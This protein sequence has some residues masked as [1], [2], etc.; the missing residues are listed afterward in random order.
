M[1]QLVVEAQP[2]PV[3][4]MVAQRLAA[5]VVSQREEPAQDRGAQEH[6]RRSVKGLPRPIRGYRRAA[7]QQDGAVH[8]VPQKLGDHDLK[9]RRHQNRG[10]GQDQPQPL[11]RRQLEDPPQDR[12]VVTGV[13]V[14]LDG[15]AGIGASVYVLP[16]PGVRSVAGSRVICRRVV[17]CH[18]SGFGE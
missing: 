2:Q 4:Q 9:D 10:R 18:L 15:H 11:R 3:R 13:A 8:R 1:L 16:R 17:S 14:L 12:R 7:Q 6:Q 5:I